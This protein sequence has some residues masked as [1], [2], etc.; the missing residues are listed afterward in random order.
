MIFCLSLDKD[1]YYLEEWA[2]VR[3]ESSPKAAR[4]AENPSG[5]DQFKAVLREADNIRIKLSRD[6]TDPLC[7]LA[8]ICMPGVGFT[9]EQLKSFTLTS[10]EIL[11][12]I[13]SRNNLQNVV[14]YFR[15]FS[16]S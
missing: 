10:Q 9:H 2:E 7:V 8:A 11:D 5:D 13:T 1:I 6:E 3:I 4:A 14:G 12:A 15:Y 16:N